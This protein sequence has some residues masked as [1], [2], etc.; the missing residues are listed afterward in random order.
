LR[1]SIVIGDSANKGEPETFLLPTDGVQRS[2]PFGTSK[3]D[4]LLKRFISYEFAITGQE[5]GDLLIEV[6]T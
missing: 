2:F 3:T 5:K 1:N 4:D 6:T